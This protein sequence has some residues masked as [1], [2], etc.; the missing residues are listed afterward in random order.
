MIKN[1]ILLGATLAGLALPLQGA[2]YYPLRLDDSKAVYLTKDQFRVAGDGLADD[3]EAIQSAI[4]KAE[5]QHGEGIVFV[6]EGRYRITRTIYVWPGLRLIGYGTNRPVFM[7]PDNSP[8]YQQGIAYMFFFTGGRPGGSHFRERQQSGPRPVMEG[9]VPPSN[10]VVD[11][12]PGTFYSAMSNVD[13]EIGSG[14]PAAVGIR[15]HVAQHCYL[16]HM[17]FHIGSGLAALKDIG[18]EAEDLHF[19]GGD[20]G[21]ITQKPSPG[22]QFTLLDSTFDGQRKAAIREHEA[23]L[24]LIHDAFRNVPEA[25][26]IDPNYAEELWA[27]DV[28]FE[29]ISGPAITISNVNNPRTEINLENI[30]CH[31]VPVFALLRET[32]EQT[33]GSGES[34]VVKTFSHGLTMRAPGDEGAIRTSFDAEA[35]KD[36]PQFGA[37]VIAALPPAN[38]W[39]NLQSLGA[40]G[41]GVTDD[42]AAVQKAIADHRMLYIPMGRYVVKDTLE[43]RPDTVLIG[44]HP[45]MTQFDLPDGTAAFQGPGSPKA[46]LESPKGGQTIVTGIGLSTGGINGRAVGAMWMAGADSLMDDVRFLGGHGTN[47]AD[48]T[49]MNPYNNTHTADPDIHRRWDGQYPS[50][51]ITNGGGGTFANIWTP[52]TFAQAGLYISNTTTPG[53]VYELS[54]EHHVRNEVK[55]DQVE[56]WELDAIQTEEE[57]GES[58]FAVPLE[59]SQ[60]RNITIA[61]Y[62]GY[63]VVSSYQPFPYAIKLSGSHDIRFRNIHVDSD[64]KAAFDNSVFDATTRADV[65]A[66]E[67]ATLNVP[68]KYE[69][70]NQD[71]TVST[72]KQGAQLEKLA[73]GFFN[74]SGAAV[75]PKGQLY[76]VD[77]HWQRIYKW[78]P[79]SKEAIVVRDNPLDPVNLGFDKAGNLIVVSY[80]GTGTVYSFRPESTMDQVTLLQPQ[81]A[82]DRPEMRPLLPVDVWSVRSVPGDRPFQYVSPD[83]T[84]FIPAGEDFVQGKLYYG[85]KMADVL[86]AFNL[87]QAAPGHPFYISDESDE[88]TYKGNVTEKGTITDLQLFAERGG[89]SVTQDQEGNV[90]LAAGQVLVYSP[91]GELLG[92][93]DVPERP[94]DLVFGGADRATL[95][96]LT[97]ASLYAVKTRVPGL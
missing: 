25:I 68:A 38:T 5:D 76:F 67:F 50:L 88:R 18:N 63:R 30:A 2:S 90:Y 83:Q 74:I 97:H 93:I 70:Q 65:R 96:I 19:Y 77:A 41:D 85:T 1:I 49:R 73:T 20:Y 28:R 51:W 89:E 84:I 64:S 35:V 10:N 34:Y 92:R 53:R 87:A 8:G 27:K 61:N 94:I 91:K 72:L 23:G 4:D 44:L 17:D 48:G 11:A 3:S 78:S 58:G 75:D 9:T 54:S 31:H 36:L 95:Y 57:R 39:A 79:E 26:S 33:A 16:A 86:R 6:P 60:S 37:N 21:I 69:P 56:N 46:L 29:N 66:Y 62:H 82:A 52:S 14:N 24:T 80:G 40:K 32:G 13:F 15:F 55:L 22:W 47:A 43:L 59:I 42:T 45:S 12:N 71:Q 81:A 7:L